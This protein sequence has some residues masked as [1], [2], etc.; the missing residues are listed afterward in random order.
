MYE[1]TPNFL[2][3]LR[4]FCEACHDRGGFITKP[5]IIVALLDHIDMLNKMAMCTH[6]DTDKII[7]DEDTIKEV[8]QNCGAILWTGKE[9]T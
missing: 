1:V 7:T 9:I 3:T 6:H 5:E 8:C 4:E 2:A